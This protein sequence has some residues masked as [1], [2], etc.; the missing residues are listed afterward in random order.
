MRDQ[1]LEF[2]LVAAFGAICF[3]C[4]LTAFIVTRKNWL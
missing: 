1:L 3:G 2:G 4:Y